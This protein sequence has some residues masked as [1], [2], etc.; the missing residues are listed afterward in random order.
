MLMIEHPA[1]KVEFS[2]EDLVK[3][4]MR[5]AADLVTGWNLKGWIQCG[6]PGRAGRAR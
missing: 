2:F 1:E 3:N 5:Q 6:Q 4:G